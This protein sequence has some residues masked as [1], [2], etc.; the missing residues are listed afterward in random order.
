ME[1]MNGLDGE[2]LGTRSATY[3]CLQT[4]QYAYCRKEFS[5]F[6]PLG[7]QGN[8]MDIYAGVQGMQMMWSICGWWT[9]PGRWAGMRGK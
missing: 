9:G 5:V 3:S 2:A 7:L 4:S 1:A 8:W 6:P